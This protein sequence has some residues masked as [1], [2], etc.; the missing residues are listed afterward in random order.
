MAIT[1]SV[2]YI[3]ITVRGEEE[4]YPLLAD[5]NSFLYDFNLLYE[6]A[7]IGSDP[8]HNKHNLS[9]YSWR[10]NARRIDQSDQLRVVRLRHES[11]LLL[12]TVIPAV[13]AAI[14][15]L[16]VMVQT[17]EKITNWSINREM[18]KLQR[19]KLRL[20]VAALERSTQELP[21]AE[22][23]GPMVAKVRNDDVQVFLNNTA[24][25]LQLN[26]VRITE[27]DFKLI[28]RLPSQTDSER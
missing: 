5:V 7:R 12:V 20:E 17:T 3:E 10:R 15:G 4:K 22:L 26:P 24:N 18:L 25:R 13:A 16:W 6:F 14:G 19:D 11:P 27:F 9:Q 8:A 28:R 21:H 23:P 2:A 1:R